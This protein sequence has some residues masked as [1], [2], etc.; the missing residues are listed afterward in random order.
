MEK[1]QVPDLDFSKNQLMTGFALILVGIFMFYLRMQTYKDAMSNQVITG[2][3]GWYHLRQTEYTVR[4]WPFRMDTDL[5]SGYPVG[6]EAGTFGTLFDQ[7]S[8]TLA[9]LIGL[10]SPSSEVVFFSVNILPV[11]FSVLLVVPVY[12]MTKIITDSSS[13][14]LV[15]VIILSLLSGQFLYRGMF[16]NADHHTAELF[17]MITSALFWL[18]AFK[19]SLSQYVIL[20]LV[21]DDKT[22]RE[23]LL[24]YKDSIVY[25][26]LAGVS[27]GLYLTVWPPAVI[28]IGIIGVA[29]ASIMLTKYNALHEVE[30]ILLSLSLGMGVSSIFPL[31]WIQ[32]FDFG[33]AGF[34][35]L[36]VLFPLFASILSL[37]FVLLERPIERSGLPEETMVAGAVVF[38]VLSSALMWVVKPELWNLISLNLRRTILLGT[39]ETTG[40]ISEAQSLTERGAIVTVLFSLYGGVGFISIG[41]MIS[42]ILYYGYKSW[43]A[44]REPR[45][46]WML[47]I[48]V[49]GLFM[50]ILAL[51][52]IRFTY[53]FS[54][55]I[56]VFA[57][58][59]LYKGLVKINYFEEVRSSSIKTYHVIIGIFI[60]SLLLPV[61]VFPLGSTAPAQAESTTIGGGYD[62]WEGALGW[63]EQNTP[64]TDTAYYGNTV[65]EETKYRESDYGVMSWWDYG[66]WITV[67]GE[68]MPV[69]NP[70]QQHAEEAAVYLLSNSTER[71]EQA[72]QDI[73]TERTE[74]PDVKYIMIDWQM[75]E[76]SSKFT[77]PTVW[78]PNKTTQDFVEPAFGTV[79]ARTQ[80]V[81]YL[82]KQSYYEAM[83]VRL[84][85]YHG[86]YYERNPVV[87]DYEQ[88]Q[89]SSN[90]KV[91]ETNRSI[92]R[93]NSTTQAESYTEDNPSAQIGGIGRSPPE[94]V[95]AVKKIR[96]VKTSDTNALRN[97]RY[98]SSLRRTLR[99]ADSS[100]EEGDLVGDTSAVKTFERVEGARVEGSGGPKND[101]VRILV[102]L[103]NPTFV[104]E[105]RV[106]TDENGNFTTTVPYS[107]TRS[108]KYKTENG[109]TEPETRAQSKYAAIH[110]GNELV[111]LKQFDVPEKK[112]VG[113]DTTPVRIELNEQSTGN[114]ETNQNENNE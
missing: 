54:G 68:R 88:P 39:V 28:F 36:Q 65:D 107:T 55:S 114:N 71:S 10:G 92:T 112:V 59:A 108:N 38:I 106:E 87:V 100:I 99:F 60:V 35:L 2:N 76:T 84:Y 69:A 104:Y 61:L 109:Y 96:L 78:H 89:Q 34:T 63:I 98:Q 1:L 5:Y 12:Y 67:T 14:G 11:V 24:E 25:T 91:L 46:M 21:L 48:S 16:G 53:Y 26:V 19:K 9:L 44:T 23:T 73:E 95:S 52:Q 62:D 75:V 27:T 33:V 83:M 77:A 8:A 82:K 113:D 90:S 79:G 49:W 29:V 32:S 72:V 42:F 47:F 81:G 30:P 85:Y 105:Q 94:D 110:Q 17:F 4:N 41:G 31:L 74:S 7:I 64:K 50:F 111:H 45:H 37:G 40:T 51:N 57:A 56:P 101:E 102:Q 18:V 13:A 103:E 22:A 93:F 15:S 43:I 66:H 70:F 6:A 86:S 3:D 97:Q 58:S 80:F 20:E